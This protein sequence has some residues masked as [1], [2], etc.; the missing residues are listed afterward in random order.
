MSKKR[1]RVSVDPKGL[2]D[3]PKKQKSKR[4]PH[5]KYWFFTDNGVAGTN[6][7]ALVE[8]PEVWVELPA[9]VQYLSWQLEE[10]DDTKHPH[11]QGHVELKR[12]QYVSWLHKNVSATARFLVRKGSTQQCDTYCHKEKGRLA[13]PFSLGVPKKGEQG[14]RTD[15][16]GLVNKCKEQVPWKQLIEDDPCLVAKYLRFIGKMKSLYRPKYDEAGEGSKVILLFGKAGCGKTKEAYHLWKDLDGFYEL[17]LTGSNT[18]WWDGLDQHNKI[19]FDDFSGAASHMRL[20]NFLKILDRYPRRVQVKG[21][22]EWLPGDKHIIITSNIHPRKWWKWE[23][24]E[25]QYLALKRRIG[26]V[27]IWDAEESM[28]EAA[29]DFWEFEELPF[30]VYGGHLCDMCNKRMP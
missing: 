14:K 15:L 7:A 30:A 21:D 10:G 12:P 22:H 13:G 27:F 17:P 6:G 23:D 18:V 1:S 16:E 3:P 2:A 8:N 26:K 19:L 20:D 9:G 5:V 29:E 4:G 25:E 24:R 11:L 28:Q